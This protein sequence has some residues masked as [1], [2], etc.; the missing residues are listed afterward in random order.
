ML[1]INTY[2]RAFLNEMKIVSFSGE[3]FLMDC[4]VVF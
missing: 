3:A 4:A 1:F 2:H